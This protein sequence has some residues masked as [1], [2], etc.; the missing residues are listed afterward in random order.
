MPCGT[1]HLSIYLSQQGFEVKTIGISQEMGV[2][3]K[4]R[5]ASLNFADK[6][7]VEVADAESLLY[8]DDSDSEVENEGHRKYFQGKTIK[9]SVKTISLKKAY[10][11]PS[12]L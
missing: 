6:V 4:D 11:S 9:C 1:G 3:T 5:I 12:V 2:Y 10:I 7:T 8:L